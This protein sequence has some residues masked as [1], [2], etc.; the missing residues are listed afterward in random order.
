[1]DLKAAGIGADLLWPRPRQVEKG[2]CLL[3]F[4]KW[5]VAGLLPAPNGES[6]ARLPLLTYFPPSH[7]PSSP[8]IFRIGN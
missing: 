4:S 6:R 2:F 1:M 7:L 5:H 3:P 8:H